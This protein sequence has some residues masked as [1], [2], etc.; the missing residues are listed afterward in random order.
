MI[1]I[2]EIIFDN[3][4]NGSMYVFLTFMKHGQRKIKCARSSASLK[5]LIGQT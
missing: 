5:L 1:K 4:H 3:K 2:S